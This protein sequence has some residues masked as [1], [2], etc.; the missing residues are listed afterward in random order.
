M[1]IVLLIIIVFAVLVAFNILNKYRKK[2]NKDNRADDK[3][4]DL[5]KDPNSNEY[6][7]KE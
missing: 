4:I 2:S 7:P 3:T 6:K 5:E 1:K